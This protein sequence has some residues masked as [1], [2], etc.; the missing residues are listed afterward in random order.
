MVSSVAGDYGTNGNSKKEVL[1]SIVVFSSV[2]GDYGTSDNSEKDVVSSIVV[3]S[4]L[5]VLLVISASIKLNK[6]GE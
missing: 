1:R 2:A 5:V 4:I 6:S 3:T